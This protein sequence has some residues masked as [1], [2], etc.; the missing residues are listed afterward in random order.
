MA[1]QIHSQQ[2]L[3]L[4][5]NFYLRFPNML[6][7]IS[8]AWFEVK[9]FQSGSNEFVC[10][11]VCHHKWLTKHDWHCTSDQIAL[12][13]SESS[14]VNLSSSTYNVFITL[15]ISIKDR[16][17]FRYFRTFQNILQ[18]KG[19]SLKYHILDIGHS[20]FH[21]AEILGEMLVMRV[22]EE[23]EITLTV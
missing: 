1:K 8:C 5:V 20:T 23:S 19:K 16:N 2:R 11:N 21:N 22:V 15:F 12:L 18:A 7:C 6:H 13:G 3:P 9:R 17:S 4:N 14:D 10:Y